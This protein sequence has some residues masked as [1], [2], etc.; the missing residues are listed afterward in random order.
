MFT[1]FTIFT[2]IIN[3]K[4]ET[5]IKSLSGINYMRKPRL[6]YLRPVEKFEIITIFYKNDKLF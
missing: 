4:I 2:Y 1:I 6:F 3:T 5:F